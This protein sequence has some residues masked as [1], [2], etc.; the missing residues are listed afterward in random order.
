MAVG[1]FDYIQRCYYI[2][3]SDPI[4][5]DGGPTGILYEDSRALQ[6][7]LKIDLSL[8]TLEFPCT[9]F[10]I[11]EHTVLYTD[12]KELYI[13]LFVSSEHNGSIAGSLTLLRTLFCS[14]G[15]PCNLIKATV[16]DTIYYG[17]RGIILYDDYTPLLMFSIEADKIEDRRYL[18]KRRILRINPKVFTSTDILSKYIK[19]KFITNIIGIDSEYADTMHTRSRLFQSVPLNYNFKIIIEDFKDWIIE[20][21]IPD[22]DFTD[23]RINEYLLDN[24]SSISADYL[25][26]FQ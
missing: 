11:I 23:E 3:P 19:S 9:Y 8:N 18:P 2:N 21:S 6:K 16:G 12:K 17:N 22:V 15:R 14:Y 13:P 24:F 7:Y 26:Y 10:K 25:S 1:F 20:P 4:T 5:F